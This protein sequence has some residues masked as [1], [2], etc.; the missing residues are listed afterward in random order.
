MEAEYDT[1]EDRDSR[2]KRKKDMGGM[3]H[4]SGHK[5]GSD[6]TTP[7][8]AALAGVTSFGNGS[9]RLLVNLRLSSRD[10]DAS[11]MPSG[12]INTFDLP[13]EAMKDMAAVKPRQVTC[14]APKGAKGDQILQL[15]M[16]KGVKIFDVETYVER[17]NILPDVAVKAYA[18]N[19]QVPG[20]RLL[21]E[22]DVRINFRA[23]FRRV[24]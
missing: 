1:H 7:Q 18:C 6:A 4:G 14:I 15:C 17:W 9:A 20:P 21:T 11:I 5:M 24:R 16:E 22:G 2:S 12:V 13:G 19:R 23:G 8:L 10:V 3:T